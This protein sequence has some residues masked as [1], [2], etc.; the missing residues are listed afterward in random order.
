MVIEIR[1]DNKPDSLFCITEWQYNYDKQLTR[2]F[3][4]IIGSK[5]E[6]KD[7]YIY[8]KRKLI[9]KILHYDGEQIGGYTKFKYKLYWVFYL[10]QMCN[11]Q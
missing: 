1:Y 10:L 4:K 11:L 6:T 5:T 3:R 9:V 8:D 2:K 7:V